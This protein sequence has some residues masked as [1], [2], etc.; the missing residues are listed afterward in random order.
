MLERES[1][2]KILLISAL[3]MVFF[4]FLLLSYFDANWLKN[5]WLDIFFAAI[6]AIIIGL[7]IE[8]IYRKTMPKSKISQS[9]VI[10]KPRK[11][12]AK[13]I[14]PNGD[15]LVI[16]EYEKVF[17]REDF[18]GLVLADD[19]LFIGKNHFKIT[20]MDD[21]FYLEDLE[22]KNG[23]LINGEE[24]RGLGKIKLNDDDEILVATTLRIKY[25]E[26]RA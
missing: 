18:L 3:L 2:T 15:E 23:T 6:I 19:L 21:G 26:E 5:R 11:L 24:I 14:L 7:V 8:Y 12:L 10:M 13:F 20:K 22:T 1:L 25:L 4:S 9:T 17:G 16:K